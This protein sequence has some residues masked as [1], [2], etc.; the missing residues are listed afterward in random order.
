[1]IDLDKIM[2]NENVVNSMK[3][4]HYLAKEVFEMV[5][6]GTVTKEKFIDIYGMN[7]YKQAKAAYDTPVWQ[8]L[9]DSVC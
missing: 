3:T 9:Y 5:M 4:D 8:T 7:T 1:M 6:S 2:E